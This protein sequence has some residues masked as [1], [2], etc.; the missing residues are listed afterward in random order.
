IKKA[1]LNVFNRYYKLDGLEEIVTQFN[2]GLSLEVSDTMSA[3][4]YVRNLKKMVGLADVIKV[5]NDSESPEAI[6]SAVEFILEGLHL[7]KRLNKTRVEDK[8]VYRR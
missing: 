2:N 8:I 1:A 5:V 6:A 4:L 3:G 7:N